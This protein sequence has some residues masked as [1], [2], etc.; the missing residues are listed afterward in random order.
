MD[1]PNVGKGYVGGL[2]SLSFA[3]WLLCVPLW[4]FGRIPFL[5]SFEE[6]GRIPIVI[7]LIP[8]KEPALSSETGVGVSTIVRQWPP[9]GPATSKR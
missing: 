1:A 6:Y 3:R 2:C 4:V 8:L 9:S 5:C 7:P